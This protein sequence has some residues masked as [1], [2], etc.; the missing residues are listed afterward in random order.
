MRKG[1]L[2]KIVARKAH[3]TK[4]AANESIETALSE[5]QKALVRGEKV[6]LSGFG[7]FRAV[8]VKDKEVVVPKTG[9]RKVVK[10]HRAARFTPGR[11]LKKIVRG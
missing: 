11:A 1:E 4:K 2:V 5:V 3:L 7:T 8:S 9:E 6:I 10:S